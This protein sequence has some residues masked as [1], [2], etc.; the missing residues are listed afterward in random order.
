MKLL[1]VLLLPFFLFSCAQKTAY[2]TVQVPVRC[3]VPK[4]EEPNYIK[5]SD[6]MSYPEL[7]K[8]L[9]EN[10][11]MCRMYSEELK[12]AMEVCQ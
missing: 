3:Q 5:P 8:A 9:I 6:Q 7:L 1:M 4:V 10:Y 2:K 11:H 12:K